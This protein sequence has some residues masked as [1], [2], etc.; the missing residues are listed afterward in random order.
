MPTAHPVYSTSGIGERYGLRLQL[1]NGEQ[2]FSIDTS[3]R[4]VSR[5][6]LSAVLR[7]GK[8]SVT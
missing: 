7:H 8:D 6:Q 2:H 5:V 4:C 1:F 3:S